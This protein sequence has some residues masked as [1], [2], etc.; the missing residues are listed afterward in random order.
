MPRISVIIPTYNRSKLVKEAVENVLRQNYTDFEVIVIDDGSIDDTGSV[1]KQVTD[2]R[3][4]YYYKP[5]GG[6]S[7]ARNV[8]LRKSSGEYIAF[9]DEDDLWP[10]DYL[11][12]VI[13]QLDEQKDYGATY[14]RVFELHPDGTKKE[15]STPERYR[16][17]WITKYYFDFSPCLMPSA[18]CFRK[19]VWE[20]FF[21]D[22]ALKRSPDYDLFLR[23]STISKFLFVPNTY[24]IKRWYPENLS[25]TTKPTSAIDVAHILER[26][27]SHM[28]GDKYV[29]QKAVKN[30]ISHRY[31]K[32]A[33][34]AS[35]LKNRQMAIQL[36]KKAILYKPLDGRLYINL[37][38]TL[39][40][41]KKNQVSADWQ[42][43][44]PLPPYITAFGKKCENEIPQQI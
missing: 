26:F 3:V 16:S 2:E 20:N 37:I 32:A 10:E 19:S 33:K 5:N 18:T 28:G 30:K 14:T 44:E 36:L 39:F 38:A 1:I 22:E 12:V 29:S 24:V 40:E 35:R 4:K 34:M 9:L 13:S 42:M 23:I 21:W 7:S 17:G 6:Q 41:S 15:L 25:S 27:Y 31:R 43:P 8:G 11:G